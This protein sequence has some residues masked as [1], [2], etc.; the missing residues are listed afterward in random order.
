MGCRVR[1]GADVPAV[2]VVNRPWGGGL[3]LGRPLRYE[4]SLAIRRRFKGARCSARKHEFP[5]L[6]PAPVESLEVNRQRILLRQNRTP[7]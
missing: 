1:D 5:D 2:R 7:E 6:T 3:T 4:Q